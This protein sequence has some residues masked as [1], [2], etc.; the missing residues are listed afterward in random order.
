MPKIPTVAIV[1]RPNVGKSTLFNRLIGSRKALESDIPGT[2]RDRVAHSVEGAQVD[3]LL[4]D[5]GGIGGGS[6]DASFE[7]DVEKQTLLA[8]EEADCIVLALEARTEPLRSDFAAIEMLRKRKQRHVPVIIALTKCDGVNVEATLPQFYS[9]GLGE[10]IVAVSAV[11]GH[12]T[13]QLQSAVEAALLSLHFTKKQETQSALPKIAVIGKPNVGKSSLLNALMNDSQREK[14]AMIVSDVPGTT[15]DAVDTLIRNEGKEYIFVDTAGL[16]RKS[17]VEE[18]M[19]AWSNMRSIRALQECDVCVFVLDLHEPISKQD[20]RLLAM[21]TEEGKG[22][23]IAA[24][25]SD[26]LSKEER[27]EAVGA[28]KASLSFCAFAFILPISALEQKGVAKLYPAIAATLENLHRKIATKHL[29]QWLQ[30]TVHS[31]PV[32]EVQHAKFCQ[33]TDDVPPTF[34]LFVKNPKAVK[35]SELRFLEKRLRSTFAF[36]GSPVRWETRSA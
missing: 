10:D 13:A 7:D 20:K 24:N 16:R 23:I 15:R 36:D 3:Y 35:A 30:D 32:G 21:A 9:L 4:V 17:H 18:D 26:L 5:T 25:K 29:T 34:L 33:Q 11:H 22:I 28:L 12:G 6:S 31:H 8:L 14:Q 27:E 1:G 2:T 19:E